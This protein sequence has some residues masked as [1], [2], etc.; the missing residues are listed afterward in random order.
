[1]ER[2]IVIKLGSTSKPPLKENSKLS[3]YEQKE[4]LTLSAENKRYA[5]SASVEQKIS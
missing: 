5:N 4:T 3:I 1:M 2:Y